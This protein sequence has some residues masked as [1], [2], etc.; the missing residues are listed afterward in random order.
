MRPSQPRN[1]TSAKPLAWPRLRMPRT[2]L[3]L[4]FSSSSMRP[5]SATFLRLAIK[6][7]IS[8]YKARQMA[9]SRVLLP[10]P[11]LPVMANRPAAPSAPLVKSMVKGPVRLARLSP[12]R[13]KIFI[14]LTPSPAPGSLQTRQPTPPRAPLQTGADSRGETP[15][16]GRAHRACA[17][18][19]HRPALRRSPDTG[20]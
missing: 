15:R 18:R 9:S 20:C 10:A 17:A 13:D 1:C 19:G 2:S 3:A 8:S 6:R 16:W 12:D 7:G 5:T 11:V 14:G 4:S